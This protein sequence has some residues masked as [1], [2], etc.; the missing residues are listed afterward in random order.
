[1]IV[2]YARVSTSDQNISTQVEIL[3]EKGCEKIFTDIASGVR[4][5]RT[6]LNEMLSYLRK[7]DIILVYKTD[8][9]F[10]S[11]KNMIDLIEKF[12]E[13]GILF[14]SITE[15]AFDTTSANGKFIIQI[16]GAVAEFERNLIS[17]RTKSGLEGARKRK[18]LLGR[19]KGSSKS[20]IEK[21]QYAKHLYDNKKISIDK[22]CRQAGISKATFYRVEKQN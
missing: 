3:R 17:E 16:F 13:K 15:P 5:D 21:Y 11:L 8:R 18:K 1:M 14:K 9:I 20:S 2:G 22:A 4:E 7:D 10:R 12:N 19:P 6:G